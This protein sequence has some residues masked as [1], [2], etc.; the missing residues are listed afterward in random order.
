MEIGRADG[1]YHELLKR[2][3]CVGVQT[4]VHDVHHRYGQ[5]AGVRAADIA[6][7]R[8][9]QRMGGG[10]GGGER[11]AENGV[12]SQMRLALRAVNGEHR[13][14]YLRLCRNIRADECRSDC[15]VHV[16]HR[17]QHALAA[18]A[19]LVA[20]AQFE[21][22]VSA[23]GCAAR[24]CRTPSCSAFGA[25]FDLDGRIAA[26]IEYL[27]GFD[28]RYFHSNRNCNRVFT[29][30]LQIA[31]HNCCPI[32]KYSLPLEL[33]CKKLFWILFR[34]YLRAIFEQIYFFSDLQIIA[35]YFQESGKE[36]CRKE[37]QRIRNS[38]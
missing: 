14:V 22:L 34:D 38:L 35:G 36:I 15:L 19:V 4:A 12:G 18:V 13:A 20:V 27:A 28:F 30:L 7:E 1:T 8:Y 23:G 3:G 16:L 10:F 6:V 11:H 2:D 37:S 17:F 32:R 5:Y 29:A 24:H 25:D 26:R 9:P 21:C 33:N 31:L